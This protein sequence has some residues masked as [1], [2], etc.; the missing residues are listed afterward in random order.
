M[1]SITHFANSLWAYYHARRMRFNNSAELADYQDSRL[2]RH[3]DW[4]SRHSRFYAHFK[5]KP[6]AT[7]PIMDKSSMMMHFDQMNTAQLSLAEVM[8][9]ALASEKN[10]DF[11]PTVRGYTTGLSSGTSGQRGVF[12]VSA[13]ERA[14]WAGIILA[15]LL[16]RSIFSGERIAFF[17][18]ANSNLYNGVQ[19]RWIT[20]KFFD[21]FLPFDAHLN[22]LM[23]YQPTILVAP[24]QVLRELALAARSDKIVIRPR[25]VIS[26]AEVLEPIDR[27]LITDTLGAPH[28][29]Y[30]ATEG[31]MGCTCTEGVMHLNEEYIHIEPEWL[32]REKRRFV[33][34]ITDFTRTTQP[35]IRYRLNDVLCVRDAP[36]PCGLPSM[37]LQTIEGRCDDMLILPGVHGKAI[38]VFAD[39]LSR[40][41]AQ[42]L[43]IHS[44]YRLLQV[45]KKQLE[46]Y[47]TTPLTD[48][49]KITAHLN[50]VLIGLGVEAHHIEWSCAAG[51]PAMD[52]TAKRR[53]IRREKFRN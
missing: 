22:A 20:F 50:A 6:L 45:G 33:P 41:L 46:L 38:T 8:H 42:I 2:I 4:I 28:E 13:R 7:W 24:A 51:V 34:V 31:F 5:N 17:L 10:R 52:P 36:C 48:M 30:Q 3:L 29:I 11:S 47:A 21:L 43:P 39:V 44:D 25:K 35:I 49:P 16:P 27:Q 37:A 40:A 9:A 26:V 1:A 15:K 18:R 12:V 14:Q 53:R 32:D 19:S 23:Q